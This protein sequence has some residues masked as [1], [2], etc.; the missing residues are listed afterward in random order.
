MLWGQ[1]AGSRCACK[2]LS[3]HQHARVGQ[4]QDPR[5]NQM[6]PGTFKVAS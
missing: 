1:L 4:F 2:V 5:P 6:L 3:E